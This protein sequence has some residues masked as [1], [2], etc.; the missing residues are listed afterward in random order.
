MVCCC[1]DILSELR[2]RLLDSD[3]GTDYRG[4]EIQSFVLDLILLD[5]LCCK[6]YGPSPTYSDSFAKLYI[7]HIESNKLDVHDGLYEE[8]ARLFK[9][10]V[11]YAKSV[12]HTSH[13]RPHT[14]YLL[15]HA[16]LIVVIS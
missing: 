7:H 3:G 10:A 8:S 11:A 13:L 14:S 15:P 1:A 16:L 4:W 2:D 12:P 5:P 9:A 6:Q